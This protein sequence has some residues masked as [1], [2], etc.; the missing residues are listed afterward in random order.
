MPES[1]LDIQFAGELV[2]GADPLTVRGHLRDLFRLS[3]EALDRLFSGR[4]MIVKRG[5]EP[6]MAERYR[7]AFRD[8]GAVVRLV[9]SRTQADP[10]VAPEYASPL[11]GRPAPGDQG[12]S[13]LT[14]APLGADVG[15]AVT[16]LPPSTIDTSYLSL[17]PGWGWSLEDC[18]PAPI[19]IPIPNLTH[20]SLAPVEP[21][22]GRDGS[23][24]SE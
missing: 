18:S 20:L 5:L 7:D 6:A 15:E 23:D 3:P 16:P 8:A 2:P 22:P 21:T 24:L 10:A 19:P 4:A 12:V 17:V 14:L 9:P 13:R 11:A 1:L